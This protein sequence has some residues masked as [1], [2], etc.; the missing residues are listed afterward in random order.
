MKWSGANPKGEGLLN[1]C[2]IYIDFFRLGSNSLAF[3]GAGMFR[4]LFDQNDQ[5]PADN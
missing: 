3:L 5:A 2:A 1:T 4:N